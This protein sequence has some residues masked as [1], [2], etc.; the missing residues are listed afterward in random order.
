MALIKCPKCQRIF[1]SEKSEAMPFCSRRCRLA[2]LN[3]WFSEE[4]SI[5]LD[6][7]AEFERRAEEALAGELEAEVQATDRVSR[8]NLR[9][10]NS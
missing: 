7:E 10:K 4:F 6:I 5:P 8:N 1:D 9:K 3:G 2:D